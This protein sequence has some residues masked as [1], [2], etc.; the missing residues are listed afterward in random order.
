MVAAVLLCGVRFPARAFDYG[1]VVER[2][3]TKPLRGFLRKTRLMRADQYLRIRVSH[4]V[5]S[6]PCGVR[7]PART[8]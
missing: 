4:D 2:V 1:S 8:L 3:D 5:K 7:F 6:G